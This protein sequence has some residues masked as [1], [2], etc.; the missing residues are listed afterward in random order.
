[1][2]QARRPGHAPVVFDDEPW[3]EDLRRAGERGRAA[4]VEARARLERDGQL[5]SQLRACDEEG[6]DGTRLPACLKVYLPPPDGPW[7]FVFLLSR[8]TGGGPVRLEYL[9]FGPRH[10]PGGSRRASVY[11]FAHR[12][13]HGEGP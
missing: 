2:T 9:A 7:G 1:M 12:R 10:P 13:L 11:A 6:R 4:A 8:S 5:I 3:V